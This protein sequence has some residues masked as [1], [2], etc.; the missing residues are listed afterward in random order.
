MLI[1]TSRPI[2]SGSTTITERPPMTTLDVRE[3]SVEVGGV[4]SSRTSFTL[5]RR[6]QGRAWS[7]AT[8]PARRSCC[9]SLGGEEPAAARPRP[10][11]AA[12]SAT[13]RR[14]RGA[15][16]DDR[17]PPALDAHPRRPAGWST[18]ASAREGTPPA[19]G[20][21]TDQRIARFA[22]LR[23]STGTLGGYAAD[24]EARTDR[25]RARADGGP[26]RRCRSRVLS[27][28]ERRR[29]RARPDPVRRQ[30]PAAARRADQPPRRR[31]EA[32]ADE[33]PGAP[34]AARCWWS[35]TTS[36]LLD[37]SIT[38]VLHLDRGELVE[39]R[40]TYS[41]YREARKRGRGAPDEGRRPAGRRD[42]AAERA[43]RLDA[44]PDREARPEGQDA[45]HPRREARRATKVDGP[46]RERKVRFRFPEPPHSGRVLLVARPGQGLR[47]A[48][49]VRA[50][51]AFDVGRGERLLVM[52]LNGAGQD[53]AA[54]ASWRASPRPTPATVPARARRLA[55]LLRAGA[56]GDPRRACTVLDHM[57]ESRAP[58]DQA[59]RALLGM[60]GLIGEMAF[61]DAGTLSGGEKTKLA[62]AQLVAGQQQ[63]AAARRADEQPRPAVADGDR[64]GA[65]GWP[66][67]MVLVSHDI[68]F[69]EALAPHRVLMMPDGTLD[70][71]SDDLLDLV[72]LA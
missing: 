13:S 46:T 63:P 42:R 68:E 17:R 54:R 41:Q 12:P 35:A 31:R 20:S 11:H 39:Y 70:Y 19:G 34:T 62:L 53:D 38:R 28:G 23:R 55:R 51:S 26:P 45:R 5:A 4:R 49:G 6:R 33:V 10:A 37:A 67:S 60:F 56:R 48:A 58:E 7:G 29:R 2:R 16:A 61:Q 71:W 64:R 52:G 14:I 36:T 30:R 66:G 21:A 43:G 57:R 40:G 72:A 24:S 47:R 69:V 59:L 1:A 44:R 18:C 25:R 65:G 8:A 32:L 27:G 50:T 22:R 3:L 15:R 9:R